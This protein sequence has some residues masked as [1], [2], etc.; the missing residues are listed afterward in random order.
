M[1]SEIVNYISMCNCLA[2]DILSTNA[3]DHSVHL[4]SSPVNS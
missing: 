2:Y 4:S 3:S 1:A